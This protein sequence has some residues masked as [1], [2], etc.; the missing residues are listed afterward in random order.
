MFVGGAWVSC[1]DLWWSKPELSIFPIMVVACADCIVLILEFNVF[2]AAYS[3]SE[4]ML[5]SAIMSWTIVSSELSPSDWGILIVVSIM[6][7][8]VCLSGCVY[9]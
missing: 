2:M 9:Q 1:P 5:G 6:G 3:K 8:K 7:L 4:L